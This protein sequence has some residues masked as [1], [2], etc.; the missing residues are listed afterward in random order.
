MTV[1]AEDGIP[2]TCAAYWPASPVMCGDPAPHEVAGAL[3]CDLHFE[4]ILQWA[5]E[6][7]RTAASL[8]YYVRRESDGMI[9]IGTSR[10]FATRFAALSQ[11]HGPLL[12]LAVHRGA[13]REEHL[14]HARFRAL[15]GEGEWFRPE[16]R[17]MEHILKARSL[18]GSQQPEGLPAQID[19][20]ELG[21]IVL[22]TKRRER[23]RSPVAVTVAVNGAPL[24]HLTE[25][26]GRVSAGRALRTR[27][28]SNPQ[29]SDP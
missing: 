2:R 12:I 17:L 26:P 29:P 25:R 5:S 11:E 13:H 8:V 19:L 22:R 16:L 14:V 15:R 21:G 23:R 7:G 1:I 3:F 6:A 9:K 4:L 20:L 24:D 10:T 28:D 18:P 27:R